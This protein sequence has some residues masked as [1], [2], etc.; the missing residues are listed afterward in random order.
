MNAEYPANQFD[1]N[2]LKN[3]ISCAVLMSSIDGEIHKSEWD[4][5]QNFAEEHWKED[6]QIFAEFREKTFEEIEAIIKEN[7]NF[8]SMLDQTVDDLTGNLSSQQKN[9][10]LNLVGDVMIAD[11]IMTLD[12][13][14]LFT[15]FMDKLGIRIS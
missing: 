3:V 11:G 2:T 9:L 7:E 10:A 4:V 6:Y 1:E 15:T 13:S 5:I 8:R 12:E 14:K